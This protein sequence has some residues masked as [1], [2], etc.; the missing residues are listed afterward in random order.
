MNYVKHGSAIKFLEKFFCEHPRVPI[1]STAGIHKLNNEVRYTG[2]LLDK[3]K[4]KILYVYC[5]ENG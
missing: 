4:L 3:K 5:G 2:L 1:L